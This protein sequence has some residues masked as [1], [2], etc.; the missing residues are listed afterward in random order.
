V[1]QD[2]DEDS[3][4]LCLALLRTSTIL[5]RSIGRTI[6][7]LNFNVNPP[8]LLVLRALYLSNEQQLPVNEIAGQMG[9]NS[10]NLTTIIDVLVRDGWVERVANEE[11]RRVVYVRLT[12]EGKAR[13]EVFLPAMLRF[14]GGFASGLKGAEKAAMLNSLSRLRRRAEELSSNEG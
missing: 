4:E 9:V 14:M 5:S 7:S 10:T 2:V 6:A 1:F 8:R 3:V 13:C 11:D 12:A